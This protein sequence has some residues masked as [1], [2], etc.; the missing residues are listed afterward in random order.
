[1]AAHITLRNVFVFANAVVLPST[2]RRYNKKKKKKKK[3]AIGDRTELKFKPSRNY[4]P[5]QTR[6]REREKLSY[7]LSS[8]I[9]TLKE[10]RKFWAAF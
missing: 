9:P 6:E 2:S 4:S 8:I 1:M 7:Y 5:L 10:E 3:S